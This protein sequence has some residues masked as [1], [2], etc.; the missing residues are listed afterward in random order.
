[1]SKPL[2][3][4]IIEII[5]W[6]VLGIL[7][8]GALLDAISNAISII[9]LKIALGSTILGGILLVIILVLLQAGKIKWADQSGI[10]YSVKS[11]SIKFY[12]YLLGILFLLWLPVLL[13]LFRSTEKKSLIIDTAKPVFS[14]TDLSFKLIILPFDK[15]CEYNGASFDIGLVLLKRLT[16]L[17]RVDT[18]D[19]NIYYLNEKID[20]SNFDE[21]DADSIMFAN[22]ADQVIFGSYSLK[23]CESGDSNKVCFNYRTDKAKWSLS[24]RSNNKMIAFEGLEDIRNGSGQESIDYL[25]YFISGNIELKK[26]DRHRAIAKW[27]KIKGYENDVTVLHEIAFSQSMLGDHRNSAKN[28]ERIT[29]ID[30]ANDL[31]Y[32]N[33]GIAYLFMDSIH[34]AKPHLEN[35][36]K[37]N[38]NSVY[39]LTGLG[40]IYTTKGYL[41]LGLAIEYYSKVTRL[42]SSDWRAWYNLGLTRLESGDTMNAMNDLA[43][44]VLINRKAFGPIT[45]LGTLYFDKH[46]Y[47]AA[48]PYFYEALE[49]SPND[50]DIWSYLGASFYYGL[51]QTD[52][53]IDCLSKAIS[54]DSLHY[55]S[56]LLLPDI[57]LSI[58]DNK[59]AQKYCLKMLEFYKDDSPSWNSLGLTYLRTG[60]FSAA[61]HSFTMASKLS[62]QDPAPRNNLKIV[63]SFEHRYILRR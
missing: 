34:E 44:A 1:M 62:P 5:K 4:K 7:A 54:I 33:L 32:A 25:L 12:L 6:V 35:A 53:A 38:P 30:P 24:S 21:K 36:L 57:Y 52:K 63:D 58:N 47:T 17:K 16:E 13:Q 22:N 2:Y 27:T 26:G 8:F 10:L 51:K 20:F 59:N 37:L 46:D 45:R 23:Q 60:N 15:E 49:L 43:G 39:A 40:K 29:K 55:K 3:Q 41:N 61:R 48:I 50:A 9:D 18:L 56:L 28:Y 42:N 11:L 31:A 19:I 14:S